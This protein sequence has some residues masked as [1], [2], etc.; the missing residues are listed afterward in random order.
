MQ[1]S[2]LV[3]RITALQRS[4]AISAAYLLSWLVLDRITLVFETAPEVSLFYPPPALGFVLLQVFGLRYLPVLLFASLIDVWFVPPINLSR[5]HGFVYALL[6]FLVYGGANVVL[7]RLQVDPGLRRFRDVVRFV[8]VAT[9]IAPLILAMLS[10]AN[11]AV[12]GIVSWSEWKLY[13]LHFWIGDSI[14]IASLAPFLLVCVVPWLRSIRL[15]RQFNLP[16]FVLRIW[17]VCAVEALALLVGIWLAFGVR[18]NDGTNFAY[19]GFLPMIWLTVRYGLP[20]AT[21]AILIINAG[22]CYIES[23]Q[24]QPPQLGFG[25]AKVQFYML[26]IS[27]TALL[28][29]ATITRRFQAYAKMQQQ[30]RQEELLNRISRSINSQLEPDQVLQDIARLTGEALKV[31]RVVIWRIGEEQVEVVTEWRVTTRVPSMLGVSV[32]LSE[33][34]D[35]TDPD[36][37]VWQ[38][39]PFQAFNYAS[40]RHPLSRDALIQQAQILSIVR[41]PIFIHDQFYGSLSLHTT[42]VHRTFSPDEVRLLEQI[43]ENA[44][45]ALYN[46]QSYQNLQQLVAARTQALDE[47]RLL[48]EAANRAKSEFVANMSHELRTP[49]TSI[50]GFSSV[51]LQQV[52]GSL[53]DRQQQYLATISASGEHLLSLI[54]D[55]LDLSRIEAGREQL[56]LETISVPVLCQSCLG[57]MQERAANRGL[58]LILTIASEITTCVADQRRLKQI[59]V[60]LLSNAVKFTESGSVTLR[61]SQSHD[62]IEFAVIDTGI[63]ID[64]ADQAMLFQPFQQLDSGIDRRYEGT[65]L[66]LVLSQKLAQL[67][68]G[69]I[70]LRSNLGQGSCFTLR[71]PQPPQS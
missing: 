51:L 14:G 68:G 12:A 69:E 47:Q 60:N 2:R 38:H 25:I 64:P 21:V 8:I 41:V 70:T 54:N 62:S 59:L 13:T 31:D 42:T 57:L 46:A 50:L 32:L 65:G 49:L 44:A 36:A 29:G 11:L 18:I 40:F 17:L 5:W 10:V 45:I 23:L 22:F 58:E 53:N 30:A 4:I 9:L 15:Q 37:D 61:V 71:L 3:Q 55:I 52:F 7:Y 16:K 43:A 26:T 19:V 28:L 24:A 27:Q 20:A 33:W 56:E 1:P 34:F 35:R 67:H 48:A 6:T 39:Q 63:G 66:G